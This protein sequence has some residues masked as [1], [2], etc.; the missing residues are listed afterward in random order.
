MM[1]AKHTG[2]ADSEGGWSP[3]LVA[4][5]AALMMTVLVLVVAVLVLALAI[6]AGF[7]HGEALWMYVE[8]PDPIVLAA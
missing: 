3:A 2:L 5:V 8:F 1:D 6:T 7:P 4:L